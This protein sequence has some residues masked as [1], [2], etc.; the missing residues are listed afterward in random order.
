MRVGAPHEVSRHLQALA[1]C[2]MTT[3]ANI[4]AVS[5]PVQYRGRYSELNS[6]N[7]DRPHLASYFIRLVTDRKLSSRYLVPPLRLYG[8]RC[9]T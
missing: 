1:L 5:L 8:T 9:F 2:S 4:L 3:S 7:D 6:I